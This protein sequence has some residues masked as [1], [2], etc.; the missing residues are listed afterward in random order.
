MA[1]ARDLIA[2]GRKRAERIMK[3]CSSIEGVLELTAQE[4]AKKVSIPVSV[5][6]RVIK[7]LSF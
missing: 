4:L 7:Q 2:I 3:E 5:A 1:V 6:E